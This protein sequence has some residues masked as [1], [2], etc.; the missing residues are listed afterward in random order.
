MM[1]QHKDGMS[2]S[3]STFATPIHMGGNNVD[4][5]SQENHSNFI[6]QLKEIS[7]NIED[8]DQGTLRGTQ[9]TRTETNF[10]REPSAIRP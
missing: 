9:H 2:N 5:N 3:I 10:T 1:N 4:E 7:N 8:K 6:N